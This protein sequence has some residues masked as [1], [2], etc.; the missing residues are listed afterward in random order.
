MSLWVNVQISSCT[1]T[2]CN[3]STKTFPFRNSK[4]NTK[5]VILKATMGELGTI[6]APSYLWGQ[7]N[8]WANV[9]NLVNCRT[10]ADLP[11]HINSQHDP[12]QVCRQ[13]HCQWAHIFCS[14]KPGVCH[15]TFN[16][17]TDAELDLTFC[18]RRVVWQTQQGA[19]FKPHCQQ[20]VTK[21][22]NIF[23]SSGFQMCRLWLQLQTEERSD[24]AHNCQ[25]Q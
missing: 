18:P 5:K 2:S 6:K 1:R 19:P 13:C 4:S 17:S 10:F 21:T 7:P 24:Q 9:W 8:D 25:S 12:N 14:T 22:F 3:A 16:K 20:L 23:P 11:Q 15:Q